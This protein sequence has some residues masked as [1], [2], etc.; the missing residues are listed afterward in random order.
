MHLSDGLIVQ[1]I[2][3]R[4]ESYILS[5]MDETTELRIKFELESFLQMYVATRAIYGYSLEVIFP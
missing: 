3:Q 1:A 5:G 2:T 4:V